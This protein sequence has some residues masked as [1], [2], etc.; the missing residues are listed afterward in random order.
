VRASKRLGVRDE[1]GIGAFVVELRL[2]AGA[3]SGLRALTAAEIERLRASRR[4][5]A[6]RARAILEL[7]TTMAPP[8]HQS[9]NG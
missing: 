3:G 6:D 7:R 9:A 5:V 1:P 4:I 8:V 2:D